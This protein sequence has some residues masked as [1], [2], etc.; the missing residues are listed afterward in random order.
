[1]YI[2]KKEYVDVVR[3][4]IEYIQRKMTSPEGG[5]SSAEDADVEGEEGGYYVWTKKEIE[6]ILG[7]E[8]ELFMEAYNIQE[9][10]N[11][12]EE[13]SKE[14]TSKNVLYLGKPLA[15]IVKANELSLPL[16]SQKLEHIRKLLLEERKQRTQPR[17]DTKILTDWN[18]LM[19]AAMTK[20]AFVLNHEGYKRIAEKATQFI[21][22][23][24]TY[25]GHKLFHS[26]IDGET[27]AQANLDDYAFFIWALLELYQCSF[28]SAY[29]HHAVSFTDV[30]LDLF[31]DDERGG[32]YFI[33]QDRR[34]VPIRQKEIH[35]G[36]SPSGNSVALLV[37]AAL[38]RITGKTSYTEKADGMLTSF[39]SSMNA[40]PT[41]SS[42]FM[43]SVVFCREPIYEIVLVGS[44]TREE[45]QQMLEVVRNRYL[46]NKVLL[47]KQRWDDLSGIAEFT[48]SMTQT[49]GDPT[50]YF[51]Q[52]YTC[53]APITDPN[54]LRALLTEV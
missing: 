11:Y 36:S 37:L 49:H 8:A 52:N 13:A 17:T 9:E 10:G 22:D 24:M 7:D 23:H 41:A 2:A 29:L 18:G 19:I 51:C 35:D 39:A 4:V 21:L 34:D 3:E 1:M 28:K 20:V 6:T 5:F 14:K 12:R 30:M 32:L 42:M 25:D 47:W 46:P 44:P 31:W 43:S 40:H 33:P 54:E 16:L 26:H 50:V 45:T 27:T 48:N 38:G 15:D 53:Q